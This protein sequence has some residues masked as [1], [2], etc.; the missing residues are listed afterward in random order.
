VLDTVCHYDSL[1]KLAELSPGERLVYL[2]KATETADH[3]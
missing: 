2:P 1:T 3:G